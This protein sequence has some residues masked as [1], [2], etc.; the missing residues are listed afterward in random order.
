[1]QDFA[2][3]FS[4]NFRGLFRVDVEGGPTFQTIV[5]P[6]SMCTRAGIRTAQSNAVSAPTFSYWLTLYFDPCQ[7]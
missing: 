2:C 6:L 7:S 4:K 1:M 5:T 3:K